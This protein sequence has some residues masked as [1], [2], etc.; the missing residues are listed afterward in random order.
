M[1]S[2]TLSAISKTAFEYDISEQEKK[3]FTKNSGDV[4]KEYFNRSMANPF[5][6]Y[7]GQLLPGRRTAIKAAAC[8]QEL[9]MRMLNKYRANPNPTKG[10]VIDLIANGSYYK[11]DLEIGADILT[12]LVAGHD[13]S[14][15]AFSNDWC[16][17]NAKQIFSHDAFY[18]LHR[19]LPTQLHS[20]CWSW[21]EI[22][23]N[24]RKC[25]WILQAR[26]GASH[27]PCR[28]RSRNPCVSIQ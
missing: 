28:W 26:M 7:C 11:S 9:V 13:V 16:S 5:R 6:K 1:I 27:R 24:R 25:K 15:S 18:L 20:H 12:Y 3:D 2:I 23:V 19:P 17:F 22:L 4:F 14:I 10:T 8:N 21:Q